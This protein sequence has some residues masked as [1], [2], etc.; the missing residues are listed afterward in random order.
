M[1]RTTLI[2]DLEVINQNKYVIYDQ[3]Q[4]ELDVESMLEYIGDPDS[5][6]RDDL[7]YMTF[8]MWIEVKKY[9]DEDYLKVLLFKLLSN[10]FAFY[11]LGEKDNNTIL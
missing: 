5:Y 1:T 2:K 4:I 3:K 6:L 8:V 7:I 9:L 11:H 10:E